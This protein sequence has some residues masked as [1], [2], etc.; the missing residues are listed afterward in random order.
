MRGKVGPKESS[1]KR[2]VTAITH[3]N[4]RREEWDEAAVIESAP[5]Q[6]TLKASVKIRSQKSYTCLHGGKT[7]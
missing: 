6:G 1:V 5:A 2:L 7:E 4:S 3:A